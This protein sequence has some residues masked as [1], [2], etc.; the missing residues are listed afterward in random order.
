MT[1][2]NYIATTIVIVA[3]LISTVYLTWLVIKLMGAW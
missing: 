3:G 2:Q 1:D